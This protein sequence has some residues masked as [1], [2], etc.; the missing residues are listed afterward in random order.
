[1]KR[2]SRS[3]HHQVL[4]FLLAWPLVVVLAPLP[5]HAQARNLPR[6]GFQ[7][8]SRPGGEDLP[9][10]SG[11]HLTP[12]MDRPKN[13]GPQV[14]NPGEPAVNMGLVRWEAKKMPLMI[15][16]S[17]GLKLPDCP[18]AEIQA[19]R[20]DMVFNMLQQ[21][22][23]F[24]GME[25][26]P[27]WTPEVN[28]VVAAGIE[29]WREFESEGLISFG[30]TEDPRRAHILVFF[31]D[32]FREAS[33]PG[34]IN[35]GGITS[36]QIYPVAQAHQINIAQ[37]PVVVE[38]ATMVN[39]TDGK[40][41]GASAHE[42]GHALGIKAHSPYRDDLMYVDRVVEELSPSDKATFRYL[43]HHPPQFVL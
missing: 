17:P 21:D 23:P 25:T 29:E 39:S 14:Y 34:G 8:F 2:L 36:A 1:M 30:F 32:A 18:F 5:G 22:S 16:I 7:T 35:V 9:T 20:V 37:K 28:E 6:A 11:L 40:M 12:G 27:G 19:T 26:A 42:F 33:S 38:L 3:R 15:W 13:A 31:T 10:S 4:I 24:L 43:Y 41:R